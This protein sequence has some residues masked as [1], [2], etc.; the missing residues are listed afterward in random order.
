M[1]MTRHSFHHRI[2]PEYLEIY[3]RLYSGL[4]PFQTPKGRRKG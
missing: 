1:S 2:V 4:D 3:H